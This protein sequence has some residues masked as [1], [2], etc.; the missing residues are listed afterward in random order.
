MKNN[1]FYVFFILLTFLSCDN[2]SKEIVAENKPIFHTTDPSRLYFQ[3]TRSHKYSSITQKDTRMDYYYLKGMDEEQT[4]FPIIANNWLAE[5]AYVLLK[6]MH[7]LPYTLVLSKEE[8]HDTLYFSFTE[9]I[10]IYDFCKMLY[11]KS[12]SGYEISILTT[13]EQW[14]PVFKNSTEKKYF[15]EVM[16]DFFRLTEQI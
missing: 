4:I 13:E 11:T 6:E 16:R 7:P 8:K 3:N 9:R 10:E 5:E 12:K 2:N 15:Q 14:V 1:Y